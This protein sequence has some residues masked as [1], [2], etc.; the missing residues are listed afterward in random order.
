[1][2]SLG[3]V[4]IDSLSTTDTE[5][6]YNAWKEDAE[7]DDYTAPLGDALIS[8]SRKLHSKNLSLDQKMEMIDNMFEYALHADSDDETIVTFENYDDIDFDKYKKKSI[9]NV[10][11][12]KTD[13]NGDILVEKAKDILVETPG[14]SKVTDTI[15]VAEPDSNESIA[16]EADKKPE[17]NAKTV[18]GYE[19]TVP[20]MRYVVQQI[21]NENVELD[22]GKLIRYRQNEVVGNHVKI[23][24]DIRATKKTWSNT[25]E[26]ED[27]LSNI[28]HPP[29]M[30]PRTAMRIKLFTAIQNRD[31]DECSALLE[32][33]KRLGG[34][35]LQEND[36]MSA[37]RFIRQDNA[38]CTSMKTLV[39][40][41]TVPPQMLL[42]EIGK[43][44][45]FGIQNSL[46]YSAVIEY[47][48]RLK[49]ASVDAHF[50]NVRFLVQ[51]LQQRDIQGIDAALEGILNG[52]EEERNR[53]RPLLVVATDLRKKLQT[54]HDLLRDS[55]AIAELHRGQ[56]ENLESSILYAAQVKVSD[57]NSIWKE[58]IKTHSDFAIDQ[59]IAYCLRAC[60]ITGHLKKLI[61]F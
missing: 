31:V 27:L 1:M 22:E 35:T 21:C 9:E 39:G 55:I 4:N 48:K 54:A 51:A 59:S 33:N 12:S 49:A 23:L 58:A 24:E 3:I 10:T 50:T 28:E 11:E 36:I 61:S 45:R 25:S 29:V 2:K 17:E 15:I 57:D 13:D 26:E 16:N 37:R 56:L 18:L 47:G 8:P 34:S 46:V 52:S 32:E 41:K 53:V 14:D 6:I 42:N 60:I 38:I 7:D 19:E 30:L 43:A 40:D 20:I 5:D 44:A